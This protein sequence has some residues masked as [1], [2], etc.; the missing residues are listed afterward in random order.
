MN[1]LV[2]QQQADMPIRLEWRRFSDF[3]QARTAMRRQPCIYLQT[4]AEEQILRVGES[5]DLWNRYFGGTAY[6]VAAAMHNSG[7]LFFVAPAPAQPTDRKRVE[8]TLIYTL[9]P[10][11]NNQGKKNLPTGLHVECS[12]AGQI[13]RCLKC[14]T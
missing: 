10:P 2:V 8:A 13:P 9:Q 6:T 11:Y 5:D 1:K 4:D 14:A 7:N 3:I 12:H